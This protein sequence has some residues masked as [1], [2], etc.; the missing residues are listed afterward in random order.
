MCSSTVSCG[1]SALAA[2]HGA[3][4][5]P[6][7]VAAL[8]TGKGRNGNGDVCVKV[9]RLTLGRTVC[10]IYWRSILRRLAVAYERAWQSKDGAET[11][12]MQPETSLQVEFASCRP[13]GAPR[14]FSEMRHWLKPA[15]T[16]CTG[17][18][19]CSMAAR[20]EILRQK[21]KRQKTYQKGT[22]H[23]FSNWKRDNAI[24]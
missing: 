4:S 2:S 1:W 22:L 24:E 9:V 20:A 17:N 15:P 7:S 18:R 13:E 19:T 23:F 10:G 3:T 21:S 11:S 5:W 6:A 16:V 14:V 8:G 12:D